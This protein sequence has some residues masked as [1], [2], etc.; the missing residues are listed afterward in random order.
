[1]HT[2]ALHKGSGSPTKFPNLK[3]PKER[4]S[5][6]CTLGG[7]LQPGVML[8][9]SEAYPGMLLSKDGGASLSSKEGL[10]QNRVATC[11]GKHIEENCGNPAPEGKWLEQ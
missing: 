11:P 6:F 10:L 4:V 1:M 2:P 9:G 5:P 8:D 3:V 7:S